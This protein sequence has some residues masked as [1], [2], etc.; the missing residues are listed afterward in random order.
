MA[1][2]TLVVTLIIAT[3]AVIFAFQN[4]T[5]VEVHF[6]TF[7]VTSTLGMVSWVALVAGILVGLL[8]TTPASYRRARQASSQ[9]KKI[10]Q[11]EK[12]IADQNEKMVSMQK[13]IDDKAAAL[14]AISEK[15]EASSPEQPVN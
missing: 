10:A 2:F 4:S 15:A 5:P 8:V 12:T 13:T 7:T 1:I 9:K 11:L 3:L 14:T 6:L